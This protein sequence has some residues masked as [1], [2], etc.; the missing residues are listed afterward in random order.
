MSQQIINSQDDERARLSRELHDEIGQQLAAILFQLTAVRSKEAATT[1]D[2]AHLEEMTRNMGEDLRRICRGLQPMTLTR[3]GLGPAVKMM[4]WEYMEVYHKNIVMR[5]EPP[6][7]IINDE[8]AAAAYRIC[9]EA[10]TNSIRHSGADDIFVS[11]YRDGRHIILEVQDEGKGF[12]M[13]EVSNE[14]KL[15][16]TGMKQRAEQC[17]GEISIDSSPGAGS[18]IVFKIPADTMDGGAL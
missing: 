2:M 8:C 1:E 18:R 14:A 6:D 11:L 13:D 9:Q 5:I 12:D 4:L 7:N 3:F 15:G 16:V 17:G 10:V